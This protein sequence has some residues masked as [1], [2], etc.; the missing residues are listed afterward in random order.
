MK[1]NIITKI[2]DYYFSPENRPVFGKRVKKAME[3]FTGG[4]K[5]PVAS[6][7]AG[8][9]TE[10]FLYDFKLE[11][12]ETPLEYFYNKNPLRLPDE[13]LTVYKNMMEDNIYDI[14][15]VADLKENK[16]MTL[17]HVRTGKEYR[18]SEKAATRQLS[19]GDAFIC[20]IIN[21]GSGYEIAGGSVLVL[22][23]LAKGAKDFLLKTTDKLT[24]KKVY[25]I[26]RGARDST[27]KTEP[28][29]DDKVL[30]TGQFGDVSSE[31]YDNCPVCRLMKECKEEGRNPTEAELIE[32]MKK[33]NG[34]HGG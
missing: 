14:F 6:E 27:A 12:G 8:H 4:N 20:R 33:A 15:E 19:R 32:A 11:T 31:E 17:E 5:T 7:D 25:G 26:V 3:E 16:E 34:Q 18:V 22:P 29:G 24:P 1:Q 30:L 2:L 21:V 23:K 28:V 10:W 13:E 9:F